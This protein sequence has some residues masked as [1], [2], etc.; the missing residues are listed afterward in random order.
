MTITNKIL[1]VTS[2]FTKAA[3]EEDS[4]DSV[5]IEGYANVATPDRGGD[6]IPATAWEDGM[7]NFLKNPIMLA[8]H[9]HKQPIGKMVDHRID[10]NGL[11]IRA[12]ISAA[13]GDVYKL[14]KSGVLTTFSVGFLV[15]DAK[16]DSGLDLFIIKALELL[17]ISVVSVPMNQD[18][19]FALAKSFDNSE[20]YLTF[21][22]QFALDAPLDNDQEAEKVVTPSNIE[23]KGILNMDENKLAEMIAKATAD[24]FA[25]SEEKRL[26]AE[27]A[28][29]AK[30][31][32]EKALEEKI[33]A[34]VAAN[35]SNGDSGADKL[36]A[37]IE[38]RF[39]DQDAAHKSVLEGLHAEIKEKAAELDAMQKSKMA[40][41]DK[42]NSK[43]ADYADKEKAVLIAAMMNRKGIDSTKFGRSLIEKIGP[44]SAS[45]TWETEVSMNMEAEI[46]KRLVVAPTIRAINMQTNVMKIPL[47]PDTG[48]GTWVTNAQFGTTASMGTTQTHQLAEITLSAYKVATNEY[49]NFE[50]EEDSLIVLTPI[51]RDAMIRRVARAVDIAY[52]RGAGA[53]ADPVKGLSTYA[54][55][56]TTNPVGTKVTVAQ[57]RDMR[58]NLG[59]FGLDPA[60][61][62]YIV[63]SDVYYD[64]LE[65]TSFQTMQ[66]VGDR[67]TLLTGQIGVIGNSPVLISGEFAT[68]AVGAIGAIAYNTSNFLAGNQRG[69]RFDSQDL[70]EAQKRVLVSSLR[71]GLTQ[72]TTNNGQGVA[73]LTWAA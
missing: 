49:L 35:I 17:E 3:Q 53:G 44:H 65:D 69:L 5:F 51:V 39:A 45:A 55:A 12:S 1:H 37:D 25:A 9:D 52:L 59:W 62:T 14:I 63:S 42:G 64:L 7:E 68:K 18:S 72:L 31:D 15:K 10:A 20:D 19:T 24:A 67:A 2:L 26:N 50:E 60:E 66:N 58:K 28:A 22:K 21:K 27:K 73:K 46:R 57:L 71:T 34:A 47:N 70:V 32:A 8:Y 38:K 4:L 29:L 41:G 54:T 61:V 23:Q 11:W 16:Y 43:D 56:N 6:V 13:A 40:F 30:A 33:K 48:V 36:M